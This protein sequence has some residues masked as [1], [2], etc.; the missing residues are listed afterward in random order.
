MVGDRLSRGTN[1]LG[2]K[3]VTAMFWPIWAD[4]LNKLS[5]IC[6]IF[7]STVVFRFEQVQFSLLKSKVFV[8]GKILCS[9]IKNGRKEFGM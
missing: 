6:S 8:L 4:R 3:C 9:E 2:T 7:G 1:Q 5:G